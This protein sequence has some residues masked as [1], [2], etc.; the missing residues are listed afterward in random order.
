[1]LDSLP[2]FFKHLTTRSKYTVV[3]PPTELESI[4]YRCCCEY[5]HFKEGQSLPVEYA[6]IRRKRFLKSR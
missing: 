2:I 5:I 1:M 3:S 6:G 4:S